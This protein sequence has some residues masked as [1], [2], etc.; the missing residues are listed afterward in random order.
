MLWNEPLALASV[1]RQIFRVRF[2]VWAMGAERFSGSWFSR[3]W[4]GHT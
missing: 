2:K 4:F 3:S 1:W